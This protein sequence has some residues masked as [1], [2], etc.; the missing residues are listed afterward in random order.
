MELLL[1]LFS[2]SHISLFTIRYA[3][4]VIFCFL[5]SCVSLHGH[6]S[7]DLRLQGLNSM[8]SYMTWIN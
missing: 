5:V 7:Y 1:L 8:F 3:I 2:Y 4:Y 6:N